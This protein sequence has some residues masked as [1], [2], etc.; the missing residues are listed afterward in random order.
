[1]IENM[2]VSAIVPWFL[3]VLAHGIY[4]ASREKDAPVA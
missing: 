3:L 2:T 4:R 1:M